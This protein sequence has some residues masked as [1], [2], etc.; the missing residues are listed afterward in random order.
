MFDALSYPQDHVVVYSYRKGNIHPSLRQENC[1]LEGR[2]GL[3]VYV[4]L[5]ENNEVTYFPVRFVTIG[6]VR[7][8]VAPISRIPERER[9]YLPLCLGEFVEYNP[10]ND[11]GQWHSSVM[12]FDALREITGPRPG[13]PAYFVIDGS[14]VFSIPSHSERTAW[15]DL[16]SKLSESSGLRDGKFLR[17]D[18]IRHDS[19]ESE[20]DRTLEGKRLVYKLRPAEIYRL[21]FSVYERLAAKTETKISV[22]TSSTELLTIDQPFQSV[23]SGLVEK[24]ALIACKRTTE[25]A[26]ATISLAISESTEPQSGRINSPSPV[27]FVRISYPKWVIILFVL[28]IGVGTLLVSVD[29]ETVKELLISS[30]GE[31]HAW[32]MALKTVGAILLGG[33]AWLVFRRL[34]SGRS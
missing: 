14:D 8:S 4:D 11:K 7:H 22:A 16:V 13:K 10:N 24:S 25:K 20:V 33:A 6:A 31:Y 29:V 18:R 5:G 3:I 34:P 28:G 15:E 1:P 12:G 21:D 19:T 26:L 32:T 27:L 2:K 17:V 23:V 9:I 30:W